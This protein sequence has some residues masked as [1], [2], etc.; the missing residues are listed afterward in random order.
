MTCIALELDTDQT[1]RGYEKGLSV[2]HSRS[3]ESFP[4]ESIKRESL[5]HVFSRPPSGFSGRNGEMKEQ[6]SGALC[7]GSSVWLDLNVNRSY[8][9]ICATRWPQRTRLNNLLSM[10]QPR[11]GDKIKY[12]WMNWRVCWV[13]MQSQ[14]ANQNCPTSNID[15]ACLIALFSIISIPSPPLERSSLRRTYWMFGQVEFFVNWKLFQKLEY[16]I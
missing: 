2:L 15:L 16:W 1:R 12:I 6:R 4:W 9:I 14:Y 11:K 13:W 5:S 10:A 8:S 7:I 3:T